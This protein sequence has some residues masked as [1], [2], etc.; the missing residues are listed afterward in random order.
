MA[1]IQKLN[2]F[3][4]KIQNLEPFLKSNRAKMHVK[5]QSILPIFIILVFITIIFFSISIVL[6]KK[7]Y[8]N[9]ENLK[10]ITKSNEFFNLSKYIISK[11]NSP[12]NEIK[13]SI[14]NND[15]I[16]KILKKYKI[17]NRDIKNIS[18]KLKMKNLSNIYSGRELKLITKK[19][20]DGKNTVVNLVFPV[21]NT[22][23]VEIRK[24][25]NDYKVKENI[26]KLYK[27][28]VVVKNMIKNNLYASAV[29]KK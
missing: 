21:N 5:S 7:N 6:E 28:E 26:L 8:E 11:I 16:E 14:K 24:I 19:L 4:K 13:Y 3:Y 12:Y 2:N 15:S 29:E 20:E 23:S 27:E 17:Q 25:N 18:T 10:D 22:T 9:S 1:L